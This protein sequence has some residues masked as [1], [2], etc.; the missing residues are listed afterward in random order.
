MC[1]NFKCEYC[2]EEFANRHVLKRHMKISFCGITHQKYSRFLN[3]FKKM[4]DRN[5]YK[6]PKKNINVPTDIPE[7]QCKICMTNQINITG[8]CGHLT[9]QECST[10][11]ENCPICRE[12]WNNNIIKI[13][14]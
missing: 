4:K 13:Y 14:F 5:G 6:T 8:I 11:L 1:T 12:P 9:C 7:I 2:H 3:N 10:Y